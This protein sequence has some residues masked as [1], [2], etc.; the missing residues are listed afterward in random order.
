MLAGDGKSMRFVM[1]EKAANYL[2]VAISTL[3]MPVVLLQCMAILNDVIP[4]ALGYQ[5]SHDGEFFIC[6]N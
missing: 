5:P 1:I 2:M 3:S 4:D 6:P